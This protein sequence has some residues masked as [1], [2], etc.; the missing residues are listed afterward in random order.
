MLSKG[1]AGDGDPGEI[2]KRR[3]RGV[4][5]MQKLE[6]YLERIKRK[7]FEEGR[8]EGRKEE[9]VEVA[10]RMLEKG[11]SPGKIVECTGLPRERVGELDRK[12]V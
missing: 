2:G 10:L 5:V 3:V 7:G 8:E 9:K 4:S 6:S 12:R 11:I 1:P